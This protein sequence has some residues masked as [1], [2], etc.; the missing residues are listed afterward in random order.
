MHRRKDGSCPCDNLVKQGGSIPSLPEGLQHSPDII[1]WFE[2]TGGNR[3]AL[4]EMLHPRH[5]SQLYEAFAEGLFLSAILLAVR[6]GF[7]R[8]PQGIVTGLFFLL[9]AAARISMECFRQPDSGASAIL[10]MTRGQFFSL[11]MIIIGIAFIAH[12]WLRG[13]QVPKMSAKS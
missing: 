5:P 10:G 7:P 2:K 12:G 1:A 3:A 13:G 8:L 4:E 11:F 6:I 9:Y